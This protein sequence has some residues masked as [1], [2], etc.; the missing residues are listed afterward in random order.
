MGLIQQQQGSQRSL[1]F[2]PQFPETPSGWLAAIFGFPAGPTQPRQGPRLT[3]GSASGLG[4]LTNPTQ[5]NHSLPQPKYFFRQPT[6]P[7]IYQKLAMVNYKL[8]MKWTTPMVP[9]AT[10]WCEPQVTKV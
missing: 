2:N 5:P 10:Q 9:G 7:H 8:V 4:N 6:Q 3:L 1:N